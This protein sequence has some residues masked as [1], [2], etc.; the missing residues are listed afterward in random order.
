MAAQ[1]KRSNKQ[2]DLSNEHP[3]S[4]ADFGDF[5]LDGT[6]AAGGGFKL[7]ILNVSVAALNLVVYNVAVAVMPLVFLF[8]CKMAGASTA[9]TLWICSAVLAFSSLAGG[10]FYW[11]NRSNR[12]IR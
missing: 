5:R 2:V 7:S 1:R 4:R 12:K 3:T 6:G 11:D 8:I 10:I 9:T